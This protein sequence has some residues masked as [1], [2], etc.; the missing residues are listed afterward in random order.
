MPPSSYQTKPY[1]PIAPHLGWSLLRTQFQIWA[2]FLIDRIARNTSRPADLRRLCRNLDRI[3]V[4]TASLAIWPRAAT[5]AV[6]VAR[7]DLP[8]CDRGH[9]TG[10]A[11]LGAIYP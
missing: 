11:S 10:I 8:W 6:L 9:A 5:A 7:D 2:G 1:S 3:G 4:V